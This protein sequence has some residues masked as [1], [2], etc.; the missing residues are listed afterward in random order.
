VP[1]LSDVPFADQ[2]TLRAAV[3]ASD[4]STVGNTLSWN[5]GFEWS[6]IPSLRFRVIRAL[7]TRAPNIGELFSPP[8]QTFPTGVQDPCVGVT[9]RRPIRSRLHA[10]P[11]L[12]S[13]RTS[14]RM[15]SSS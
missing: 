14:R 13:T 9:E 8:S 11:L 6:P 7:S 12:A 5:G 4:Y 2:L 10:A 3:R 15:A 1:I